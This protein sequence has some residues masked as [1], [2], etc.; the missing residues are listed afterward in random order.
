MESFPNDTYT[1]SYKHS[2]ETDLLCFETG[3]I[4]FCLCPVQYINFS[5]QIKKFH[6][7]NTVLKKLFQ[8]VQIL[9]YNTGMKTIICVNYKT[10]DL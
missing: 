6:K 8:I 4:P 5:S 2:A 7:I 10:S 1:A 9:T 3:L